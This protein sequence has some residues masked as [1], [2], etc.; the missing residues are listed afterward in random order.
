M[1]QWLR[2][3]VTFPEDFDSIRSTHVA[4]HMAELQLQGF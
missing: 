2:T 3:L 1:A 4:T